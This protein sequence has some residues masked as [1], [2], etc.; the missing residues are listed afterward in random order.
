MICL[1]TYESE[2]QRGRQ[3]TAHLFS[4]GVYPMLLAAK[5]APCFPTIVAQ[6]MSAAMDYT[7]VIPGT[8]D[9][10]G[11]P[12]TPGTPD[13]PGT[14][15]PPGTPGTPG[16]QAHQAHQAHTRPTSADLLS[17]GLPFLLPLL[18]D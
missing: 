12:G 4:F 5:F 13:T 6:M 3:V 18:C 11:T 2:R 16:N 7:R 17:F 14:P 1:L 8:P 10:P 9:T 15:G